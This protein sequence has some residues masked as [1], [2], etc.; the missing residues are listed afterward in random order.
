MELRRGRWL[1]IKGARRELL[2]RG[3]ASGHLIR[4]VVGH[5][6]WASTVKREALGRFAPPMASM[7]SAGAGAQS[8][9]PAVRAELRR[10][11]CPPPLLV[12]DLAA[13]WASRLVASDA[14][15]EGLG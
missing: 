11:C 1:A 10:A 15:E 7:V 13:P 9:W 4:A 14:G 3:R 2:R 5:V 12:A 6:A 8:L